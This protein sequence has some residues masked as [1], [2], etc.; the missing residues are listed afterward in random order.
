MIVDEE[1]LR[2][3][4]GKEAKLPSTSQKE[5]LGIATSSATEESGTTLAVDID[6]SYI[7]E[8]YFID[9]N[10]QCCPTFFCG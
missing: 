6:E 8:T 9:V 7:D 4:I 5:L 10:C 3:I 1:S 2:V